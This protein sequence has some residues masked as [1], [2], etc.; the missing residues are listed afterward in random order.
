MKITRKTRIQPLVIPCNLYFFTVALSLHALHHVF[1]PGLL[2][3]HPSSL[4]T[5]TSRHPSLLS[6]A[7]PQ[8]SLEDCRCHKISPAIIGNKKHSVSLVMACLGP[9]KQETIRLACFIP[10]PPGGSSRPSDVGSPLP[11]RV[12][13]EKC[14]FVAGFRIP[15]FCKWLTRGERKR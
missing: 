6:L 2:V 7:A 14:G 8:N 3:T 4:F 13:H 5:Y 9:R 15:F 10:E 11:C 1:L 12:G